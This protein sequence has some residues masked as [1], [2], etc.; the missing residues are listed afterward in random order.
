M[1]I[2]L[3]PIA[4]EQKIENFDRCILKFW[5]SMEIDT[6]SFTGSRSSIFFGNLSSISIIFR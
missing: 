1:M 3:R 6:I 5:L 2:R 4:K